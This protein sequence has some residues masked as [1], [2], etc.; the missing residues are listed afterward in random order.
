LLFSTLN[1]KRGILEVLA[2]KKLP[3]A[4]GDEPLLGEGK[5]PEG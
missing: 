4:L 2:R 5:L 3:P 1:K